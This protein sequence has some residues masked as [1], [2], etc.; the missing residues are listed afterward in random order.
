MAPHAN[1][2]AARSAGTGSGTAPSRLHAASTAAAIASEAEH[3]AHNYHPLPVVFAEAKGVDVWDPEGR[4]YLDFLSAYSAVNQG[5]CHPELVK[6]LVDQA[7]RLT[8]SSRAF[9]ND[10]FPK[11]A[12]KIRQVFGYEMV[13]PMNTGVEA[14]ETAVK[15]ARKWAYK[16]KGVEQDKALVLCVADNFHGRSMTAITLSTDPESKENY[17]PYVPN[18]GASSP[19]TGKPIRFN[20]VADL[21]EVLEAHGKDTA[22]F[23]VEP[24]QGE[25]GV[26]V[27]DDD[28]LAKVHALCKKHKVLLICDE[29]QTGIG[30][31]GRM[32]CSEWSGIKPDV[33]TLGKAISGG[34]YPVSA[35][36]SS[37]EVMLVVEPGTHG[38]TYG[39]NPLG[40]AVSIRAL[41]LIEEE[42]MIGNAE[43]LG[44]M[45]R[46]GLAA[47]KSPVIKA[48]RGKG[49]LNAMVIDESAT[50]GRTAW[51]LCLLLK[52]KG[53]LA[54]PTHGDIIRFAPPLVITETELRKGLNIIAEAIKELPTAEKAAGH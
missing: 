15:I 16:V 11:W 27:P 1:D 4:H 45:F 2:V 30:R 21:E 28:Y 22:A 39:G 35:V 54:K 40:C 14:V 43:R 26:V 8:L 41:E 25:A 50:S 53:L 51:D 6:A 23:L 31:T 20:N 49:L 36:M 33:V 18:I 24:I 46:D 52:K 17:G 19:S 29:V 42:N 3:A 37:K 7:G 44:N 48:I 34:M 12:E 32:L 9:H 38:S 5:H 13:L 10:V 47:L